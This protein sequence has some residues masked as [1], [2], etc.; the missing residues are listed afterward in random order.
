MPNKR[1][2][3]AQYEH[4]ARLFLE[5]Q[6][7]KLIAAN[8][9][10]RCGELDLVMSDGDTTVFIEVRQRS[11][12]RFGG[13]WE[14][15]SRQKQRRWIQAAEAWLNRQRKSLENCDCRFDLITFE[16]KTSTPN[17]FKHFIEFNDSHNYE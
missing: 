4:Q 13:A 9:A 16:P 14:S 12:D 11:D 6:G 5:R 8:Q 1:E 15:V 2:Q 7:L 10:F 3:G 17:W